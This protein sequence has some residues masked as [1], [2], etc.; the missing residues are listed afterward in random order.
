MFEGLQKK[1]KVNGLQLTLILC[2]FA[3][4]GSVTGFVGKKIM[5]VLA[6]GQDW[7]WAVIYIVLVTL[8]WPLMV[9]LISIPFGQFRFFIVYIR[10]L[11]LKMGVIKEKK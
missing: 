3:I 9:I 6:I 5:N 2:T 10:K 7:L 1:W 11:G 8:L 4:G